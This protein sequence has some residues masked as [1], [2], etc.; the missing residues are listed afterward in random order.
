MEPISFRSLVAGFEFVR[1]SDLILAAITL[2]LFAVLLGGSTALLP[3]FAQDI[4]H[5]GPTGL[6]WLRA[7]PSIGAV[8]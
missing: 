4:L 3:I 6:G 2:D 5:V 1:K 8:R 7:A